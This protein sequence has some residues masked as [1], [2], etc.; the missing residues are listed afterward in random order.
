MSRFWRVTRE[1]N[2]LSMVMKIPLLQRGED[3][4][5]I[6]GYEVEQPPRPKA[7]TGSASGMSGGMKPSGSTTPPASR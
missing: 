1:G 7:T 4:L 3:P 6:I 5:N 2:D